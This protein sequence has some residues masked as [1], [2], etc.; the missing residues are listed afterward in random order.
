VITGATIDRCVRATAGRRWVWA[1]LIALLAAWPFAHALR[2]RVPPPPPVLGT[3]PPFQLVDQDDRPFGSR[4]LAG[5]VWIG[6]VVSTRGGAADLDV[7]RPMARIQARARNLEPALHLVS[8]SAD[9]EHDTPA[10]LAELARARRAS[11]RMWTFLTGPADAV[12][13]TVERG[14]RVGGGREPGE[15]SPAASSP[16][17]HLVLVDG[18]ARIRGYY[19]AQDRDAVDRVVRDAALLVNDRAG[20]SPRPDR[21]GP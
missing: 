17:T 11:P 2:T 20:A 15:A 18:A 8:F 4:D 16:R 9:P 13:E 5:R 6:S 14:L 21:R 7:T 12:R 19:D 1:L 10:R 3:V